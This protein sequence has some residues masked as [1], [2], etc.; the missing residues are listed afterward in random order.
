[1]AITYDE[2]T[3]VQMDEFVNTVLKWK[4]VGSFV[5]SEIEVGSAKLQ[6]FILQ[7]DNLF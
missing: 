4:F 2:S 6:N 7:F 5:S 1:M 3:E